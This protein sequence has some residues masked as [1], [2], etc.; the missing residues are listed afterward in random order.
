MNLFRTLI[1]LLSVLCLSTCKKTNEVEVNSTPTSF[2]QVFDSYWQ[3]MN[4]HYVYWDR[5]TINWDNV[6]KKYA[7]LFDNLSINN[8]D[9]NL[10]AAGY[11][12]Q[13]AANII[14]CHYSITFQTSRLQGTVINPALDR[15]MRSPGFH[16][17][18][19]F[20]KADTGYLDKGYQVGYYTDPENSDDNFYITWGSIKKDILYFNCDKFHLL[21][22][23]NAT[24]NKGSAPA[25]L[26][27]FLNVLNNMPANIKGIIIDIRENGG[28]D[29]ADL[30][31]LA[32]RLTDKP[33]IF[34]KT[35]YKSNAGRLDYTPWVNAV[36][37]PQPVGNFKQKPVVV[38]ADS[39]SAS[40]SEAFAMAVHAMPKGLT[41]GETTFGATGP[42]SDEAGFNGGP[43]TVNGFLSVAEASA[44]FL[45]IDGKNYENTGFPPDVQV[46]FNAGQLNSN[47]D[48]QLEKAIEIL[49]Q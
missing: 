48:K 46:D 20:L 16:Y 6:Y 17:P 26:K 27:S 37:S 38:L 36:V 45:Y 42:I 41:V 44:Q 40:L 9:D 8:V 29:I 28:G 22:C 21:K 11:F 5:D 23:Y 31:F 34:G 18:Y 24:S 7:P 3:N 14:D 39:F 35:R 1:L 10:K 19:S 32:G 43:F 47:I 15:K 33:V 30:N 49:S 12:K 4:S 2:R 25:V 13:I